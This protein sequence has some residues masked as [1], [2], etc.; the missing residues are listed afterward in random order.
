MNEGRGDHLA[1]LFLWAAY[2]ALRIKHFGIATS[3]IRGPRAGH[4]TVGR[5]DT[6]YA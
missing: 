2:L 4:R 6:E 5:R 3:Q 1:I